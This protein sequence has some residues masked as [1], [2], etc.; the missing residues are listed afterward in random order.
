MNI[1]VGVVEHHYIIDHVVAVK[2]EVVDLRVL[3]VK[4]FLKLLEGLR[5][6]EKFHY[7]IKIKVV[8]R[9]TKIFLRIVLGFQSGA[10]SH[11]RC[12]DRKSDKFFHDFWF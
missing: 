4:I 9:Q 12:N 8:A 2:I 7:C 1:A 3:V 5:L 11:H 10:C 6:P